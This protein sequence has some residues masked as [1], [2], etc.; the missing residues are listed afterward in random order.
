M[1]QVHMNRDIIKNGVDDDAFC[2]SVSGVD[3]N[4]LTEIL[5]CPR[6]SRI[7]GIQY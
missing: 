1:W 3:K 4:S 2:E 6:H 5:W 7:R